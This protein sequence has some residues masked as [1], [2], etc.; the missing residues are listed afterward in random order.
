MKA[1][2]KDILKTIARIILWLPA[3]IID[4]VLF[5]V[6]VITHFGRIMLMW[7]ISRVH[8]K[9]LV[10]S[11]E[12]PYAISI[13]EIIQIAKDAYTVIFVDSWDLID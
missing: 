9:I 4:Q 6:T 2:T 8:S 1:S 12:C 5:W 11:D 13:D 10:L 7:V 3:L